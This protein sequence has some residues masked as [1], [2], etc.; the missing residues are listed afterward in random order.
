MHFP[1]WWRQLAKALVDNDCL[2]YIREA[3]SG[4]GCEGWY[5]VRLCK[6]EPLEASPKKDIIV[7]WL[8]GAGIG[9][10]GEGCCQRAHEGARAGQ[11]A[12][13]RHCAEA[14]DEH[15]KMGLL[16]LSREDTGGYSAGVGGSGEGGEV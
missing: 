11:A 6:M 3:F 7:G 5:E 1:G 12:G 15:G 16:G 9:G 13:G 10:G 2:P 8:C 4:Q 14:E